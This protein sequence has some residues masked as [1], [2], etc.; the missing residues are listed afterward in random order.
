MAQQVDALLRQAAAARQEA[1]A[2][3]LT[4]AAQEAMRNVLAQERRAHEAGELSSQRARAKISDAQE[5]FKA[6]AEAQGI[7]LDEEIEATERKPPNTA[8][9][10]KYS[11]LMEQRAKIQQQEKRK[12]QAAV[13]GQ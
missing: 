9:L 8:P 5:R 2:I 4:G 3:D 7:S 13:A 1:D 10:N 12:G 6:G 11:T